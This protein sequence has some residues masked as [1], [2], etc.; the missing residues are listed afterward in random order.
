MS[1]HHING[2]FFLQAAKIAAIPCPPS[3]INGRSVAPGP[4]VEGSLVQ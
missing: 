3:A 2:S 4:F 1:I